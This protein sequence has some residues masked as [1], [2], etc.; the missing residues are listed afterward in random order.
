MY[1][2]IVDNTRYISRG[3]AVR[4]ISN[5]KSDLLGDS[6]SQVMGTIQ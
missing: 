1:K 2:H 6:S 5:S 3:I 4:K